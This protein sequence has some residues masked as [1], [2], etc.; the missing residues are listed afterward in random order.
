MARFER[1]ARV[2]SALNH[3]NIVAV[4]DVGREN[5][6]SFIVSELVEGETLSA[7]LEKGPVPVRKLIDIGSQIAAGLAAA[8]AAG[9]IHRDLKPGNIMLG[10]GGRVKILD[11]GLASPQRPL[12][13]A[14]T[15]LGISAPGLILGTPG[16]MSPE[17]VRGEQADARSDLFSLGVVLY[18]MAAGRPAF[19]GDS[20]V[21]R[22]NATLKDDP[23]DLPPASPPA[24]ERIVRRCLEKHPAE[25][26]QSAADLGFAL[27][28]VSSRPHA[29]EHAPRSRPVWV[30]MALATA[31]VP[32]VY[33]AATRNPATVGDGSIYRRLT[34]DSGLTWWG[35]ISRD[36]KMV[37]YTSDRGAPG[38]GHLW[39]QQVDAGGAIQLTTGRDWAVYPALS[40]DGVQVA[41]C[42]PGRGLYLASTLGGE[43]RLVAPD[44]CEA[45]FS[46]DGRNLLYFGS[47]GEPDPR[48]SPGTLLIRPVA[49]GEPIELAKGCRVHTGTISWSPDDNHVLFFGTCGRDAEGPAASTAPPVRAWVSTADGTSI[50]V[51]KSF[52][53]IIGEI[54][55]SILP[56]GLSFKVNDW[57]ENPSRLL[58]PT[59]AGDA[60]VI[61]TI[62]VSLDGARI[63]GAIQR[64]AFPGADVR[65]SAAATGRMVATSITHSIHIWGVPLGPRGPTGVPQQL[66]FGPAQE[67]NPFLSSDGTKLAFLGPRLNGDRVF[68]K[69]LRTGRER[70]V[71]TDG[72]RFVSPVF[73]ADGTKVLCLQYPRPDSLNATLFELPFSTDAVPRRIWA[74]AGSTTLY[75]LSPDGSAAAFHRGIGPM[76]AE[77][78]DVSSLATWTYLQDPNQNVVDL[79][80]SENGRWVTFTLEDREGANRAKRS[81][82]VFIAPFRR[83]LVPRADWIEVTRGQWDGKPCFSRGDS[84]VMMLSN[85]DGHFCIW[86]QPLTPGM[87]PL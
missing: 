3:P 37:A 48:G 46:R 82:R 39:V 26:F 56:D 58:I 60:G 47:T 34:N 74:D 29:G 21:E 73:S 20:S 18:E 87:R 8:H 57:A 49:G 51:S 30:A 42:F 52:D 64:Q 72:H 71:S 77:V 62:P 41:F 14:S 7:V 33:W 53:P 79:R 4:H 86:S 27:A 44:G 1:E 84:A 66:T 32:V 55:K 25:R 17:Q 16:Y 22:L 59:M 38:L 23:P 78:L 35:N 76:T 15:A 31:A 68:V 85:R 2:A 11:F 6:V 5:G 83:S 45:R 24:L 81:S 54:A 80:F 19:G 12:N 69:D 28:S 61:L 9:V 65:V 10:P 36:G 13:E 75:D 67:S 70:E 50:R 40:P 43:P 63:T